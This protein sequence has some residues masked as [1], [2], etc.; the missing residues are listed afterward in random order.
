MHHGTTFLTKCAED[1]GSSVRIP[2][3]KDFNAILQDDIGPSKVIV[4]V[5]DPLGTEYYYEREGV[6]QFWNKQLS[7][8]FDFKN[9]SSNE[10]INKKGTYKLKEGWK[11][12]VGTTAPARTRRSHSARRS[13][14]VRN[15]RTR[16]HSIG[17][18]RRRSKQRAI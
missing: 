5:K 7:N 18:T 15:T 13:S 14:K 2:H 10:S 8:S 12:F 16:R 3:G 9:P 6:E 11:L 17:E 4:L 1:L